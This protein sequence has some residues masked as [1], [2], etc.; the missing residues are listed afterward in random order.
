MALHSFVLYYAPTSSP[1]RDSV[2]TDDQVGA[3]YIYVRGREKWRVVGQHTTVENDGSL[4]KKP[5]VW[6]CEP[7]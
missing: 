5:N 4:V 3:G 6:D 2:E 7:A 1:E